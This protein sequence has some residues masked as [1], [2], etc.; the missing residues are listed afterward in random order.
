MRTT[1][2]AFARLP[3]GSYF[4]ARG[5][6]WIKGPANMVKSGVRFNSYDA[7]A[8]MAAVDYEKD[9]IPVEQFPDEM[10]VRYDPNESRAP[11]VNPKKSR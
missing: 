5:K 6:T 7:D 11:W 1:F 8:T 2:I 10:L 4:N 3:A 9:P